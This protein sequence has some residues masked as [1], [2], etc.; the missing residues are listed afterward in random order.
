MICVVARMPQEYA[1]LIRDTEMIKSEM[2]RVEDKVTRSHDLIASLADERRRWEE[3]KSTFT[4]QL[5]T[6]GGDSLISAAFLA[7]AG[8]F[9]HRG[10]RS[11]LAEWKNIVE[12]VGIRMNRD[13]SLV[14]GVPVIVLSPCC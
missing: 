1:T 13:A 10:R 7:Y 14:R 12:C 9:D 2:S 11:L 5:S 8:Y 6:L 4:D 3:S